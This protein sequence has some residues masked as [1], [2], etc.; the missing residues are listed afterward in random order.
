MSTTSR[1][2]VS[3]ICVSCGPRTRM[4]KYVRSMP[5]RPLNCPACWAV[6][7]ADD[8]RA[9]KI[10]AI[11]CHFYP[12]DL[13]SAPPSRRIERSILAD[14]VVRH[15]GDRVAILIAE[16][17]QLARDA[18]D[19][20]SVEYDSSPCVTTPEEAMAPGAIALWENVPGN[21]LFRY[22]LG[23]KEATRDAMHRARN[24]VSLDLVNQ[25]VVALPLEQRGAVGEYHTDGGYVLHTSAQSPHRLR[26]QLA[27]GVLHEPENRVRVV[28]KDV[29]GAFGL[30]VA[31]FPEE[32]LVL[33]AARK[34]RRPVKW[35]PDRS[36]SFL[37]DDHARD[38][39]ASLKMGLDGD[40]RIVAFEAELT[41]N[42]G[43]YLASTGTVS[44]IFGPQMSTGIYDLPA[45]A[46]TVTGVLT[47][48]QP[49]APYR[50]AGRPEAIFTIERLIQHAAM[51]LGFNTMELRRKNIVAAQR[52]PYRT[53]LGAR[54][55]T[56]VNFRCR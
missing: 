17:A 56:A 20:V 39:K 50:G 15:V 45:A 46:V 27:Q 6:L 48:T 24:V 43:A 1:F 28:V 26:T 14:R 41:S 36:E 53:A 13:Y 30:K 47:N 23:D 2:P 40:G 34:V 35:S 7:T 3:A 44:A 11:A 49:I 32:A 29:G 22:T 37:S 31:L 54:I 52:M 55:T 10:G 5:G 33:W 21:I 51:E 12:E 19:L 38:Q 42:L 25:R 9:D 18:A 8:M 4:R 16:T